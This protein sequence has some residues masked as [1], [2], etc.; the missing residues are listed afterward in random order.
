MPVFYFNIIFKNIFG[1]EIKVHITSKSTFVYK[2]RWGIL[3]FFCKFP[4]FCGCWNLNRKVSYIIF[5]QAT[6]YPWLFT[7]FFQ[8]PSGLFIICVHMD[9]C[10]YLVVRCLYR[11]EAHDK[12]YLYLFLSYIFSD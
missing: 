11:L 5:R 7:P 1:T 6:M 9:G 4:Y 12:L 8:P 2:Y 10:E 3:T